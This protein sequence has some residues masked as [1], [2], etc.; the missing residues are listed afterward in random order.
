M[1]D[2][3][4]SKP[5]V[6]YNPS[7]GNPVIL[8]LDPDEVG[9][10]GYQMFGSPAYISGSTGAV[11]NPRYLLS[12]DVTKLRHLTLQEAVSMNSITEDQL[13][14]RRFRVNIP[15]YDVTNPGVYTRVTSAADDY[16]LENDGYGGDY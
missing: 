11:S 5:A 2:Y 3:P 13:G 7:W 10:P 9:K 16:P 15:W 6:P 14:A 12:T 8:Y 4:G 1:A